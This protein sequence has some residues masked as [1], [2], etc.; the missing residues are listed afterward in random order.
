MNGQYVISCES[1]AD[2]P[3]EYMKKRDIPILF[4]SYVI[5]GKEFEDD[6]CRTDRSFENFYSMLAAGKIPKTSQINYSHY[7]DFFS[8][9]IKKGDVIHIAFGSGMTPSVNN[10][11]EA[12]EKVS[13]ENPG[14]RIIVIDSLC[15]SCGYG[16]LVDMAADM[17]DDGCSMEEVENCIIKLRRNIHHQFFTTDV[18]YFRRSGRVSGPIATVASA[19]NI[20]P[21]MHLD[22]SGHIVA[23]KK[24]CGK[25]NAIKETIKEMQKYA[26]GND[27]YNG[28]CYI[29]HSDCESDAEAAKTRIIESFE[30][31]SEENIKILN[32]GMIT[33]SH[34][35]PGTVAVFF[36]GDERP[37]K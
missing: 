2:L 33:A 20:C 35:G 19:L 16:M 5:D 7:Y 34:C 3:Y 1:T 11:V 4:Y 9:Q 14:K 27:Q 29:A 17:K 26:V 32:I 23:Y 36:C 12:A 10:A 21:I 13:S 28:K 8:E 18:K 25:R 15:S 31:L 24:V 6:M 22:R 37:E 30:N